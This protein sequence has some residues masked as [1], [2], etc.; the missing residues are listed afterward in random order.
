VR[1]CATSSRFGVC[2]GFWTQ[3]TAAVRTGEKPTELAAGESCSIA[4]GSAP[5][6]RLLLPYAF[7]NNTLEGPSSVSKAPN[8]S[9]DE[10]VDG[11]QYRR[12]AGG[13]P[14][15]S[16]RYARDRMQAITLTS[17]SPL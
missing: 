16:L 2:E 1:S 12:L 8:F 10:L 4:E 14:L 13:G 17:A 3:K 5:R 11:V 15:R 6:R 9:L 7:D